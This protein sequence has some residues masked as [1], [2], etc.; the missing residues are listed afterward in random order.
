[1]S[2]S[3]GEVRR[4]AVGDKTAGL[5]A[6]GLT[7]L[8]EGGALRRLTFAGREVVRLIDYPIRDGD[9]ATLP[10]VTESE[11]ATPSSYLRTF[12]TG[13]GAVEGRFEA[14]VTGDAHA[15]R[16]VAEL[17]LTARRGIVVNRAG[18]I[19]LHPLAG[20]AGEPVAV[21]HPD[22]GEEALRFPER[23]APAQP[24]KDIAALVHQ[25]REVEVAIAFDGEVF[26]M[27]DQRN[28]TDASFK[29]YC[30]PLALPRPYEV[31]AGE[32]VRQRITVELRRS[33]AA[34]QGVEGGTSPVDARMPEVWL[35][36]EA[37]IA[38]AHPEVGA[39]AAQ[40]VLVRVDGEAGKG[41]L[42]PGPVTLEVVTGAD[43][44]GDLRAAKAK[45]PGAA[46][47]VALP[48][49]YLRS[50]QPEGPWPPGLGPM[51]L[52]PLVRDVFPGAEV[53][54]GM[55]TNF[56]E[57]NRCPPDPN[58]VDFCT[59]GTTAIV[60]AADDMSVVETLEAIPQVIASGRALSGD[61]P[62]R[63]GLMAIGMRSNPYGAGVVAN[64]DRR[65]VPMAMD[66]PRQRSGFAAAFAV[67]VAAAC[68]QGGVASFAPAMTG[69]PLGMADSDGIWP[70]GTPSPRW[71]RW[72]GWR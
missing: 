36:H 63:L 42:P 25:V 60:H 43:A 53:G 55:L 35:A 5:A 44:A 20:V 19:V 57:F 21:R 8:V 65:R 48:R 14:V 68:A 1:M 70:S 49:G 30:R 46:R 11:A 71:R 51:D 37:G 6:F 54:G 67:A 52:V 29:T 41:G 31:R 4:L 72:P 9:W 27:E 15:A 50:H 34:A 17:R 13:D 40:G 47:V 12:R 32:E 23:I 10:T 18:F 33:G 66:D 45:V 64:P 3:T 28:W 24:V 69:G 16:I 2:I 22:A 59:F 56:T 61:R 58:R 7:A 38:K 62:L 26:E 39:L